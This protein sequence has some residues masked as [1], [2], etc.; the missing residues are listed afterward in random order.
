MADEL[1]ELRD[2]L[3]LERTLLANE[4]TFL[5]FT[6]TSLAVLVTGLFFVRFFI[7]PTTTQT[8]HDLEAVA[9]TLSCLVAATGV[10]R[11]LSVRARLR[12]A[13]TRGSRAPVEAGPR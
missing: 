3:A 1:T 10:W 13:V 6:R 7:T 11:F 8:A 12:R 9:V 4:R 2:F 5:A